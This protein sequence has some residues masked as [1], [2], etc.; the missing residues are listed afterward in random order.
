MT[1]WVKGSNNNNKNNES[2]SLEI[3]KKIYEELNTV[4]KN[5]RRVDLLVRGGDFNAKTGTGSY[6]YPDKFIRII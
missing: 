2:K 3:I 5:T 4:E 6:T 1:D